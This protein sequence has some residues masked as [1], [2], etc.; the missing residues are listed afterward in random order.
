MKSGKNSFGEISVPNEDSGRLLRWRAEKIA[1]EKVIHNRESRRVFSAEKMQQTLHE[2]RVHQIE[3]EMQNEELRRTQVELDAARARYFDLYDLAPIGYLTLNERGL[4]LE[5]NLT[6]ATL[7]E[8]SRSILVQYSLSSFIHKEDQDIYYSRRKK[9]FETGI[10]QAYELRMVKKSGAVFWAHLEST[11]VHDPVAGVLCRLVL[12]D[13][14][15]RKQAEQER[16]RLLAQLGGQAQ[17]MQQILESVPAG[18]ILLDSADRLVLANPVAMTQLEVLAPLQTGE[19]LTHLGNRPLPELL[20]TPPQGIWHEISHGQQ[21]FEISARPLVSGPQSQGYVLV[22]REVTQDRL[23]QRQIQQQERLVAI[24]QL[25]AGIAHDFN[26]ILAV[27]ILYTYM[28]LRASELSPKLRDQL[29]IILDESHRASELIQQ[30]LDFSRRA[31][32]ERQS[33]NLVSFLKEQINLLERTLPENIETQLTYGAD[34]YQVD[35][36][37]TRIQ[38]ILMNLA[39][40][41]RDAMPE[42]GV[43][44]LRLKRLS[45][46][47]GMQTVSGPNLPPGEWVQV[48]VTDTGVGIPPEILPRIFEPFFTTKAPLGTGLGLAQV[49]GIVKLHGGE[50]EV[51]STV[52][53]G[54]TFTL[55]LP[56]SAG[57]ARDHADIVSSVPLTYGNNEMI[58]IVED[59]PVVC[60]ALAQMLEMLHYRVVTA[61]NGRLAL[62]LFAQQASEISLILSDLV[63]PEMGGEALFYAL[64]E[65]GMTQPMVILSGHPMENELEKLQNQGLAG[66]MLKPPSI[67]RLAQLLAEL[68]KKQ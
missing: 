21:I 7:F 32:L 31:V 15:E 64:K 60:R 41:A 62:Q 53:Q 1:R 27:I 42:G 8:I 56:A 59:N 54:T 47:S 24:G 45:I 16:E 52:G 33:L 11:I 14:T 38:Q 22:L 58:L 30:I 61:A 18:V 50:I 65:R 36:D 12:S 67:E 48:Q 5:A 10:P 44:S 23:A 34:E 13:I 40:N 6:A 51:V 57:Q 20:T 68:L 26:N 46:G 19:T 4:I 28:A 66:W 29:H 43:L 3:L 2:L 63:M 35:A 39:V 25:A 17:Q 55:Y 9:L 37:P 49:H